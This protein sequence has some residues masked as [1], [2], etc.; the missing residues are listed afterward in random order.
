MAAA[1]QGSSW[2]LS[3]GSWASPVEDL[4]VSPRSVL[5]CRQAALE[6][7]QLANV[8]GCE[9][10]RGFQPRFPSEKP[11]AS[12]LTSL[13]SEMELTVTTLR[14]GVVRI[15]NSPD[16]YMTFTVVGAL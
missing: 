11:R 12:D 9:S 15:R 4:Q 6:R 13:N 1:A 2:L 16:M 7:L 5:L 10:A 8:P 14:A 3:R